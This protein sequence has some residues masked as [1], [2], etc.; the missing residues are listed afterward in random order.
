VVVSLTA[1]LAWALWHRQRGAVWLALACVGTSIL[2]FAVPVEQRWL[3]S[4]VPRASSSFDELTL[5]S[6]YMLVPIFA[7]YSLVASAFGGRWWH[8]RRRGAEAMLAAGVVALVGLAWTLDFSATSSARLAGTTWGS[9]L[10]AARSTCRAAPALASTAVAIAPP[11][12]TVE[13]PCRDIIG[14]G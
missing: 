4:L 6:R 2:M 12:W 9:A 7:L 1:V 11:G 13:L 8:A 10:G 3:P 5:E 14:S